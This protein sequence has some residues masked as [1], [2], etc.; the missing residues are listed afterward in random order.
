VSGRERSVRQVVR[1]LRAGQ[2]TAPVVVGG[3]G[4]ASDAA[5][6]SI[7]ADAYA[8]DMVSACRLFATGD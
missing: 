3:H 4:I 7:G 8:P 6:R 1:A 2:C 5:A